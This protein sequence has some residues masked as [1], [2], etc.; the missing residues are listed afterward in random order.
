MDTSGVWPR[1]LAPRGNKVTDDDDA[2]DIMTSQGMY[3]IVVGGS[4]NKVF[5]Y[6]R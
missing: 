2:M 3:S 5:V 4:L 1:R 6:C